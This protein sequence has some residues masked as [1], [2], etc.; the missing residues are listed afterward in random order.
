ME[1]LSFTYYHSSNLQTLS[2]EKQLYL[3]KCLL[4]IL[5]LFQK[6]KR[7]NFLILLV[8]FFLVFNIAVVNAA[9]KQG[10]RSNDVIVLQ[11][12]LKHLGYFQG[13]ATGYFGSQTK[14]AVQNFQKS[15][16]LLADG[17]AGN[18][19]LRALNNNSNSTS[20]SNSQGLNQGDRGNNVIVLQQKLKHLGYFQGKVTGYFGSQ[21]KIAVQNFQKSC[22][23]LADGVAGNNTLRALNNNSTSTSVSN[24]S[25]SQR[26]KRG[27]R[28]NNIIAL[29]KKLQ[30]LG[31]F[32]GEATGYF[33]SQTE[34]AVQKFQQSKNLLADGIVGGNTFASLNNTNNTAPP[35]KYNP[36]INITKSQIQT[37]QKHLQR[38][39]FYQGKIDGIY[40]GNTRNSL[41]KFQANNNINNNIKLVENF[42]GYTSGYGYRYSSIT[43]TQE[44]HRGLD[45]AAPMDSYIKNWR[46]GTI[47]ELSDHTACGTL[48]RV[49]SGNFEHVYCHLKGSIKTDSNG[50]YLYDPR[51]GLRIRKGQ[52]ISTGA[53]IGR[54]GMTG[55]TTGPHLHWGLKYKGAFIDPFLVLLK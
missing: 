15:R 38:L 17:V 37:V 50:T 44:L 19:T 31:Y 24:T 43:R 36:S 20:V 29:Q 7:I 51:S 18:K 10:D 39:G 22:N 25:N 54:I 14:V 6:I 11:Q 45:F 55:K 3:E 4:D 9:L 1:A 33:G 41:L 30:Q 40:G 16:N 23:L 35:S 12:K 42:Q 52:S 48:V 8:T 28:G 46:T 34:V 47:I 2:E 32:Q 49:Q 27:D 5:L 26:L 21:T 53:R 13:Q